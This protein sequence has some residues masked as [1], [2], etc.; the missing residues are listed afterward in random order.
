M[1]WAVIMSVVAIA[2]SLYSLRSIARC[3][4]TIDEIERRRAARRMA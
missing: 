3:E 1:S 4:R 2:G